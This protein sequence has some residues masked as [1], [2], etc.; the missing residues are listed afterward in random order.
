M[1]LYSIVKEWL[2]EHGYD[3]LVLDG[4][5]CRGCGLDA[6]MSCLEPD[7]N[8]APAKRVLCKDCRSRKGCSVYRDYKEGKIQGVPHCYKIPEGTLGRSE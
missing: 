1:T 8:C 2:K 7:V 3:G 5:T 4:K 6:L